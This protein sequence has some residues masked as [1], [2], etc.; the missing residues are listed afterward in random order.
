MK[1]AGDDLVEALKTVNGQ[2]AGLR[3]LVSLT[4][5]EGGR[6]EVLLK[7][8]EAM[9]DDMDTASDHDEAVLAGM[10]TSFEGVQKLLQNMPE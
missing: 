1:I 3:I 7:R 10:K 6:H 2:L 9:L 5:V 8:I 4:M